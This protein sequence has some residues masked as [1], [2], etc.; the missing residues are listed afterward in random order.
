MDLNLRH[1][2]IANVTGNNQEQLEH[3]IVDAIQ[4]G[5]EKMLPGPRRFI[6]GYLAAR[7]RK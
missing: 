3:T 7:I 5:E 4:S 1:A 6:R 2:V